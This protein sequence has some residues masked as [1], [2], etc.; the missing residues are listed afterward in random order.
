[1]ILLQNQLQTAALIGLGQDLS[2]G[3]EAIETKRGHRLD[4]LINLAI[5]PRNAR[6]PYMDVP[7]LR[8]SRKGR[9]GRHGS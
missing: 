6:I 9:A 7:P 8:G 3:L 1:V 4:R 2:K 5:S